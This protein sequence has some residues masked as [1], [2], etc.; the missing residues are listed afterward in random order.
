MWLKILIDM[1]MVIYKALSEEEL[2]KKASN[3]SKFSE[4][5]I[6]KFMRDHKP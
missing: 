3:I 4:G 6:R 2:I 1:L 5:F